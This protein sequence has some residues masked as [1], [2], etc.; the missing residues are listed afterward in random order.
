MEI[1]IVGATGYIGGSV[2]LRLLAEGHRVFGLVRTDEKAA[3][4]AKSGIEPVKGDLTSLDAAAAGA[5]RADVTINA[6]NADDAVITFSLLDAL[7]GSGK[8]FIHTSGTSVVADR[9]AGEHSSAIFHEDTPFAP[10][11]ERMLRVAIDQAVLAATHRGIRTVVMRPGLHLWPR[12][13]IESKQFAIADPHQIGAAARRA[14]ARRTWIER[15]VTC[16]Y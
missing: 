4:L 14:A 2:G 9:A 13:R 15:M 6:A 8:T 7:A 1:F 12:S 11:P 3:L 16:S 10:L 5:K